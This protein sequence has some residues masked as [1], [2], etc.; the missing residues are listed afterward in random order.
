MLSIFRSRLLRGALLAVA[1]L[2]LIQARPVFAD[3]NGDCAS[4]PEFVSV[5]A[6]SN[7]SITRSVTIHGLLGG[8]LSAG[9]Y[10]L[11]VPPGAINGTA[12]ITMTIPDQS[13]L[14]CSLEISPPSANG[15][16][17]PVMLVAGYL[18]T[19][20]N[21]HLF[22]TRWFNPASG[23]WC[24]VTGSRLSWPDFQIITPLWHFSKYGV[25]PTKAGW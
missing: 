15:F 3:T 13:V 22:E 5:P 25:T 18:G 6:S 8:V 10:T 19:A 1:A 24:T 14:Q 12:T 21:P 7:E 2:L 20:L 23:T 17:L 16:R 11:I 4:N 9:R